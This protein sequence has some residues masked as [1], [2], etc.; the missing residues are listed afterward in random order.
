MAVVAAWQV[1]SG[2]AAHSLPRTPVNDDARTTDDLVED[3]A[4]IETST[5][6]PD[7]VV[8]PARPP[9]ATTSR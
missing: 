8:S 4:T 5:S 1:G 3:N 7:R 2:T 6:R 9:T